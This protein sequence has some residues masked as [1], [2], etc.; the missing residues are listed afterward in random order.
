MA[1]KSCRIVTPA[2]VGHGQRAVLQ[3]E[4]ER[5]GLWL[6]LAGRGLVAE[7]GRACYVGARE[8][9]LV[10]A[11]EVRGVVSSTEGAQTLRTISVPSAE[12]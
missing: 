5:T 4:L 3:R 7:V 6:A 10:G 2:D 1:E 8:R 9:A 11:G 12:R